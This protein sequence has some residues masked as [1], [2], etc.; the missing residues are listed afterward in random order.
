MNA[1]SEIW[2][3]APILDGLKMAIVHHP[4][5]F[6]KPAT[7]SRDTLHSKPSWFVVAEDRHGNI[8]VGECSLIPGLS[9]ESA[10]SAE[11]A[12]N[13]IA[14][15]GRLD[16]MAVPASLPA[17]RFAVETAAWDVHLGG[18]GV[19]A[20][21]AFTRGEE[22]IDINGLV[23][24][25]NIDLMIQ[26][27]DQLASQGFT[28]L[29][30]KVG[31]LDW[32][33]ELQMLQMIRSRYPA[34]SFALRVDANGAFSQLDLDEV[35]SRLEALR[36]LEVHSIEQPLA[37]YDR[38][39]LAQICRDDILPIALDESMIGLSTMMERERLLDDV[40]PHY[41]VLKPSLLGGL[42]SVTTWSRLAEQRGIQWWATS[43]LESNVG[44]RAIAQWV[45]VQPAVADAE[46]I[47]PQGLGTGGLFHNNV[48]SN[49]VVFQGKLNVDPNT[50]VDNQIWKTALMHSKRC[51]P[52]CHCHQDPLAS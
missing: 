10:Q 9:I 38:E 25:A 11:Q 15:K 42:D 29:K 18:R 7:T 50:I 26:Q 24:M 31:A 12:L 17:V 21:S 4:L 44:L 51:D 52:G 2:Q 32:A 28:T 27:F 47:I 5:H 36:E 34:H 37:P 8:G 20:D 19:I 22:S 45:A 39:R 48:K 13:H 49:L 23:W 40:Q 43:A 33:S 30:C 16:S 1:R 41:L 3:P 6:I 14:S 46:E 35:R